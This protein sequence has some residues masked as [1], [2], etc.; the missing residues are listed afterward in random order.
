M[1]RS[2][3]RKAMVVAIA[4]LGGAFIGA[5]L[6]L[7]AVAALVDVDPLAAAASLNS[8]AVAIA[9]LGGAYGGVRTLRQ[10]T[11]AD[12]RAEWWRRAE[13]CGEY[14]V[15][16]DVDRLEIAVGL[17][18]ALERDD[19][20]TGSRERLYFDALSGAGAVDASRR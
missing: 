5:S 15:S 17:L 2:L 19:N 10:R 12:Q 4:A 9:A 1:R 11:E 3:P 8:T 13:R 16:G 18:A 7:A 14:I 20:R 6:A